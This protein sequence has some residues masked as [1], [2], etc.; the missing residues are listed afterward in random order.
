M[1]ELSEKSRNEVVDRI[2]LTAPLLTE[3]VRDI[4]I[5]RSRSSVPVITLDPGREGL[6]LTSCLDS[7]PHIG[8]AVPRFLT[9]KDQHLKHLSARR[10]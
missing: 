8:G 6:S 10:P 3:I 1:E 2:D 7:T 5:R 9:Q 4:H